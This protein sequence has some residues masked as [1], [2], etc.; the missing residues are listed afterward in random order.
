MIVLPL[1][2]AAA[3]ILPQSVEAQCCLDGLFAGC[4]SCFRK[5]PPAYAVAPVMAPI[6]APVPAPPPPVVVPVQ[7]VS[8]VP[9]TTYRTQ[10]QCVPVTSYK[11]SCEIDPCTGCSRD[12]ME[13]VTNY[14]QQAVNV[15][16]TQYRAVYSTKYVQMQPGAQAYGAPAAAMPA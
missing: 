11:P 16:V 15:P 3:S 7:Q 14:V 4:A 13:Q 8:Y 9:E 2:V 1:A 6:A 12:C 5:A 10:Y